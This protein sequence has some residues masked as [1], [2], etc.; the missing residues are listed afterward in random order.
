MHPKLTDFG[1]A[2]S[3]AEGEGATS[4]VGSTYFLAPEVIFG[5][6]EPYGYAVD[7][8]ALGLVAWFCLT[9]GIRLSPIADEDEGREQHVPPDTQEA[10]Y[11]WMEKE[12]RAHAEAE[13]I[14]AAAKRAGS[15]ASSAEPMQPQREEPVPA[16]RE[17]DAELP[18]ACYMSLAALSLIEML[19]AESSRVRGTARSVRAHAFFAN[20]CDPPLATE[21]QWADLLPID[22]RC[23]APPS[24]ASSDSGWTWRPHALST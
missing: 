8:Y 5:S 2:K 1:L 23:P 10:L 16:T 15:A 3:N 21:E 13:K 22:Q 14:D 17:A 9:G 6:S 24:S 20:G 4:F 18:P 7:L 12:R 19:T 11:N